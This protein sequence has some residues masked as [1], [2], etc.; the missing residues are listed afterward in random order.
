MALKLI[1][2]LLEAKHLYGVSVMAPVM[3]IGGISPQRFVVGMFDVA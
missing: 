1:G 3:P 2:L